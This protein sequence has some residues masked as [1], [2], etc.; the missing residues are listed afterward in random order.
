MMVQDFDPL[1]GGT[2]LSAWLFILVLA[3]PFAVLRW[4]WYKK[5][6]AEDPF[7]DMNKTPGAITCPRCEAPWPGAYEPRSHR[8]LMWKGVV[9]PNCGCEYDEWGHERNAI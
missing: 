1:I 9:C 7:R 4:K 3:S 2:P 8:E 5:R 6:M